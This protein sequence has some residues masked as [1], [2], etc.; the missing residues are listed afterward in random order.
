VLD[1]DLATFSLRNE[2]ISLM[3][4][5]FVGI[6]IGLGAS[7]S[8][9]AGDWPT[10]EMASRGDA[11]GLVTGIAIAIPSGCGVALSILGNN[12]S[13]LVGV[14]ISASL[15]PPVRTLMFS[16]PS[17]FLFEQYLILLSLFMSCRVT[18]VHSSTVLT[19]LLPREGCKRRHLL[20]ACFSDKGG[21]YRRQCK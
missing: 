20:D 13:S 21:S 7:W 3:V 1:W 10:D 5:I 19:P 4:S 6:L 8:K 12:T 2:L 9:G 15:L 17:L 18:S 14:A 11:M 16:L